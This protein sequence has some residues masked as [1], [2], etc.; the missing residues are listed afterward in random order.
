MGYD[1]QV[2]YRKGIENQVANELS[3][4][5]ENATISTPVPRW[6]DTIKEEVQTNPKLQHIVKLFSRRG[7]CWTI[8]LQGGSIIFQESDLSQ[9]GFSFTSSY[10]P[11]V[12]FKYS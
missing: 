6:L 3:R 5:E 8:G 4:K 2:E 7:G 1:F 11:R 10:N 12:L 9:L